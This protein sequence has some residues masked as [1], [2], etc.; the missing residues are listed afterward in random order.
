MSTK[1]R[2]SSLVMTIS[3]CLRVWKGKRWETSFCTWVPFFDAIV[4]MIFWNVSWAIMH[5]FPHRQHS[6]WILKSLMV[7]PYCHH[8][9][10]PIIRCGILKQIWNVIRKRAEDKWNERV[11]GWAHN[12]APIV[13]P[14]H[15]Q[16]CVCTTSKWTSTKNEVNFYS[17]GSFIKEHCIWGY[18]CITRLSKGK[19]CDQITLSNIA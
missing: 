12:Q 5:S 18:D 7:W 11:L 19:T 3:T 10:C 2:K 16:R 17:Y 9:R 13:G 6:K 15:E 1:V 4:T 14:T 8:E